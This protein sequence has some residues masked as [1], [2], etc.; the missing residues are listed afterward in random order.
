[1]DFKGPLVK[2]LGLAIDEGIRRG[3]EAGVEHGKAG[4]S[5]S[6]LE[7]Y[8]VDAGA[9]YEA[10]VLELDNVNFPLLDSLEECAD[11]G[12]EH[13]MARLVL[14]GN[15]NDPGRALPQPTREQLLVPAYYERGGVRSAN[16]WEH[17][18]PLEDAINAS[19]ARARVCAHDA[20]YKN[21]VVDGDHSLVQRSKESIDPTGPSPSCPVTG[22]TGDNA[23]QDGMFVIV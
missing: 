15:P 8:D 11:S 7:A 5:L 16:P 12:L 1:M 22:P 10:A 13:L 18:I 23:A 2:C 3:L 17:V 19:K 6:E 20:V 21:A 14:E 9:K 4:L